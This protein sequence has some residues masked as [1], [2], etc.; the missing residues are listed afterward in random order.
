MT[1]VELRKSQEERQVREEEQAEVEMFFEVDLE[2]VFGSQITALEV[3]ELS[4][5][6]VMDDAEMRFVTIKLVTIMRKNTTDAYFSVLADRAA[7]LDT[8][9]TRIGTKDAFETL[10]QADNLQMFTSYLNQ[11]QATLTVRKSAGYVMTNILCCSNE[12]L[13]SLKEPAI[14]SNV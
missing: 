11:L 3:I 10:L 1:V 2:R 9:T 8:V 7:L 13:Y 5:D 12:L 6:N 4:D 14:R